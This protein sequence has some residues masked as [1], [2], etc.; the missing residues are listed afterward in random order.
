MTYNSILT[1]EAECFAQHAFFFVQHSREILGNKQLS[2]VYVPVQNKVA[3][4][5]PD[6]FRNPTLGTYLEWWMECKEAV[7]ETDGRKWLIW[8][9]EGLPIREFNTC[10]IVDEKGESRPYVAG[11]FSHLWR[12]FK[13]I[14][15]R[16]NR[17]NDLEPLTLKE[18]I[19]KLENSAI[20]EKGHYRLS[21][22]NFFLRH[23]NIALSNKAETLQRQCQNLKMELADARISLQPDWFRN[24]YRQYK[25]A[26]QQTSERKEMLQEQ[27]R[28]LRQRLKNSELTNTEYQHLLQP[29]SKELHEL[30]DPYTS[31][32]W[33]L[34]RKNTGI[35]LEDLER[36]F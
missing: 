29:I 15:K 28:I 20:E 13:A 14:N 11:C 6:G 24:F 5:N 26:C 18:A 10:Y 7:V 36:N 3:Y 23:D 12:S 8:R 34:R 30:S 9:I 22:E 4:T 25:E 35:T 2:S 21:A 16:Q 19:D 1:D 33:E 17:E 27:R 32:L 31:F